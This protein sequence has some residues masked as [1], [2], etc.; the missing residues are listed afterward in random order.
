MTCGRR[1]LEGPADYVRRKFHRIEVLV[2]NNAGIYLIKAVAET[3]VEE[4]EEIL[5]RPSA[6]IGAGEAADQV[7]HLGSLKKPLMSHR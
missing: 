7:S 6:P 4:L 5:A 3:T 2:N 1:G